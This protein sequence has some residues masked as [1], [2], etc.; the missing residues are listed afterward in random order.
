MVRQ[1]WMGWTVALALGAL[2]LAPAMAHAQR[3]MG[4]WQSGNFG[5]T[6]GYGLSYGNYNYMPGYGL[7]YGNPGYMSGYGYGYNP[8]YGSSGYSVPQW[9][10]QTNPYAYGQYNVMPGYNYSVPS[11]AAALGQQSGV[12]QAMYQSGNAPAR[13]MVIVPAPDAQ[14]FFGDTATQQTGTAMREF[15]SPPLEPGKQFQYE[16]RAQWKQGDQSKEEKKTVDVQAGSRVVVNFAQQQQGNMPMPGNQP[17][18]T[19]PGYENP[20]ATQPGGTDNRTN[21]RPPDKENQTNP[22]P[23]DTDK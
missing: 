18:G 10:G 8:W 6:P 23:P 7:S 17:S 16:I 2:L 22:R 12:T 4:G 11:D 19:R 9:T 13:V 21:P 20:P 15:V 3:R 1:R 5:Y 14:V